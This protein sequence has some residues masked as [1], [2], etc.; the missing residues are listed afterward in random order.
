MNSRAIAAKILVQVIYEHRH[1]NDS[2]QGP[3]LQGLEAREIPFVK[4]LAYGV[5]RWYQRLD[6]FVKQLMP[7]PLKAKDSDVYCLLL[8]G[9]YQLIYMRVPS[10]AA[11]NE[12]VNALKGFKKPWARSV[13]NAVLRNFQRRE[14]ELVEKAQYDLQAL[15]SHPSWLINKIKKVYP[16]AWQTVLENNN[17]QAPL[18]LRVNLL[19][20]TR[21]D[22]LQQLVDLD[23]EAQ[24]SPLTDCGIDLHFF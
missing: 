3:L 1:L 24:A 15:Y 6:F 9:L 2:L 7:K 21:T 16:D 12:T 18:C 22:Y 8:I 4:E 14:T 11:I 5:C 10:H 13:L 19:K 17:L 20:T 23:I